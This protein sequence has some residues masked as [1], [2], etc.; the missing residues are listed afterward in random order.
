MKAEREL[1]DPGGE[2][3]A[4]T[5]AP[6]LSD[7]EGPG[8][9]ATPVEDL[10]EYDIGEWDPLPPPKTTRVIV[11]AVAAVGVAAAA[12]F[13]LKWAYDRRRSDSGYRKAVGHLEDA[14]VALVEA[15]SELPERGRE[16]LNRVRGR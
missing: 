10:E 1:Q 14:R 15:A 4:E 11:I 16:V 8:A 12:A 6:R 9:A 3:A 2:P 13:A 5:D 7:T